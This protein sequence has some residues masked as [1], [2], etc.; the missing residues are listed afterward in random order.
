V[1]DTWADLR[2]ARTPRRFPHQGQSKSNALAALSRRWYSPKTEATVRLNS[3]ESSDR[4]GH[5]LDGIDQRFFRLEM[6]LASSAAK[7]LMSTPCRDRSSQRRRES[8][9]VVYRE[10]GL[11]PRSERLV[12]QDAQR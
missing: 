6:A 3:S 11:R 4:F 12:A 5:R 10:V 7:R 1:V 2:E 9:A 8:S